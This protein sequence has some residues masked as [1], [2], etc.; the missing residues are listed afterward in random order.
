MNEGRTAEVCGADEF[1]LKSLSRKTDTVF[2]RVRGQAT[3][4][5]YD[6]VPLLCISRGLLTPSMFLDATWV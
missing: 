1:P 4:A 2:V 3:I 6:V 5:I